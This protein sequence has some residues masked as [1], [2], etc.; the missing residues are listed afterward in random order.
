V[1]GEDGVAGRGLERPDCQLLA[2]AT[3][4]SAAAAI[5]V[6]GEDGGVDDG[7]GLAEMEGAALQVQ[8]GPFKAA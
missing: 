8:V 6:V 5:G 4:P 7:E 1:A 3:Q 2:A